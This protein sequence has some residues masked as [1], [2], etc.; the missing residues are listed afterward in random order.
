[1]SLF[2]EIYLKRPYYHC[3]HCHRGK[4][5]GDKLLKLSRQRITSAASQLMSLAGVLSSFAQ[6]AEKTLVKMSGLRVS[7]STVERTTEDAGG[8]LAEQLANQPPGSRS[9]RPW[10]WQRDAEGKQCAYISID[11]TG[12]RQQGPGGA[13]ADGRMVAVGMVYNPRSEHDPGGLPPHQVR[14][15]AGFYE[16]DELGSRLRDQAM[17]AGWHLAERR[18]AL[19]DGGNGLE[20]LI[21][22]HFPLAQCILDFWHASEHVAELARAIHPTD[23]E[24]FAKLHHKWCHQ[25]KHEG[26]R[27]LLAELEALPLEESPEPVREAHRDLTRYIGNN[28]HR[29]DYPTYLACGWQIGSGPVE[30]ACKTVIGQRLKA[31]G[32]RWGEDGADA[33][34]HLRALYLSEPHQWEAFW[35]DYPT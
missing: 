11:H 19:S 24:A 8:Q 32:M 3:R 26:G 28:V 30:A 15:V 2:G 25:M 6:A 20:Q 7:E 29:M 23:E 5:L 1:M 33:V 22:R 9:Y 27:A 16:L 21:G 34:S 17:Q 13:K 18:I 31:S 12:V 10:R 4:S 35:K 14:Y